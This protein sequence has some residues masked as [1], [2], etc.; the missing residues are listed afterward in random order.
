MTHHV[1]IA[2]KDLESLRL[3]DEDSTVVEEYSFIQTQDND[4]ANGSR[5]KQ[6]YYQ[7][8]NTENKFFLH[9]SNR[10]FFINVLI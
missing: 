6:H 8:P 1:S 4:R 7:D 10:G 2:M 9:Y 3:S 5:N